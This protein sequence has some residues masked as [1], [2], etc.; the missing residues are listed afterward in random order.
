MKKNRIF[1]LLCCALLPALLRAQAPQERE[2]ILIIS[3]YYPYTRRMSGFIAEFERNIMASGIPCDIYVETLECKSINDAP[4]WMSQTENMISRYENKG[5]RAIVL[6]GQ[7]AWASFVSLG[8]IPKDVMCF[9][10]YVS[11]NGIV[12]PP[13][14]DSLG[15]WLPPSINY[16]NMTDSLNNVGGMLNKYDV[17]RNIEL[18][19]S[20]F[21]EAENIAFISDNTY[22][23]IS[24]QALV[25]EEM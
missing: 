19:R 5:L 18:V 1:L 6:L 24:L 15:M 22:G 7:E 16:M 9:C 10:C 8:H 11:S 25:R 12:L 21:P 20:L 17:R 3:S 14:E 23:G 2:S 13:P 4:I